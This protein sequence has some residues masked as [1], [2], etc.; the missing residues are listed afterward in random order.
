MSMQKD[1]L[2]IEV[3]D[4]LAA[5]LKDPKSTATLE[6]LDYRDKRKAKEAEI[7]AAKLKPK[8]QEKLFGIF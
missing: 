3:S 7:E 5:L 4:G 6:F 1:D 8:E 2:G